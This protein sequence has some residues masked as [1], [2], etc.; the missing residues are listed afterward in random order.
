M[1][2]LIKLEL[3]KKKNN[4]IFLNIYTGIK[5]YILEEQFLPL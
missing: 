1:E 4:V 5:K 2:T 3:P